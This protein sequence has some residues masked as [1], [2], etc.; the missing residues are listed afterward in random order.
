[1]PELLL[2]VGCE[3][4]PASFVRKAYTD[5]H[6]L[7]AHRL[8]EA[9]VLVD[10]GT[11][12]GTPRRLI[13]SIPNLRERQEDQ[14]KEQR[15]P[16][17]KAAFNEAGD[18]TPAL[19]G[20]CRSQGV[21]P[22]DLRQE[23][24]YVWV[25]KV[26]PG[27][28]TREL[29][30]EAIPQALRELSFEK[31]MRW[32][33]ARMRFARPIRWILASLDGE[34]VGFEVESVRSGLE[35]RGHRFYA[36]EVFEAKRLI[37]LVEGLRARRVEPNPAVRRRTI[38]ETARRVASGEPEMSEALIDENV[39]L[40][41]WPTPLQGEYRSEFQV[42]PEPVLVTAMAKHEKM[43]PVRGDDGLLTTQFIFVR[44]SGV[45]DEV[46]AGTEWVLNARF[47]DAKFFF[48]E[49][50]THT[51]DEFLERTAGIVVQEKLG[52]VRQRADRLATLASE[53][54]LATGADH[55]E[56]VL[57]R[58]A[59][60]Y[61]KADLSTG[62]VSELP[63]LQGVVGGE[64]ARREGM[65]A[66]VCHAVASQYDLSKNLPPNDAARRTGVRL[67]LADQLDK[68][69][70]YLGIGLEP[71]GSSDPYGLRRAGT[72]LIQASWNWEGPMPPFAGLLRRAEELY[73]EQG[74]ALPSDR[75][76]EALGE[77][78]AGRYEA[79]LPEVRHDLLEAALLREV[80]DQLTN[81]R[82]VRFR[83]S[84][85][86]RISD[87]VPFVQAATRPLNI[88][89]AARKKG[90]AFD[91]MDPLGRLDLAALDSAEGAVLNQVLQETE[92]DL[93]KAASEESA[94][95][96]LQS[97]KKLETPINRF[98]DSTM[99]MVEQEDVRRARLSLLQAASLQ[100]L[101]AGDFSKIVV[102]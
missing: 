24:G 97:L 28:S 4:L 84:V 75:T 52:N 19:L 82:G 2:E 36:P 42:L 95:R 11:S 96:V 65:L 93:M 69:A 98:F 7:I 22:S 20:F 43:F 38:V 67:L 102:A 9:G 49:D 14:T 30:A 60:L 62:L 83:T 94:D 31:S 74:F 37:D 68:L 18:P 81:P 101:V 99:I 85:L 58:S 25:T 6:A 70:G 73:R 32:G 88:V 59:G 46:R 47:N 16:G 57:A 8:R 64:Y 39:F 71:S 91:E 1:M 40:T 90:I 50:V 72:L 55:A 17:L 33:A 41:E 77:I 51:L 23:G 79:M 13:V 21:D 100:L 48:D 61:A 54:A 3:E 80:A 56:T 35:S 86:T 45:D 76:A 53:I 44:N 87:D 78:L 10:E 89:A 15:G 12:M 27:R 5:L 26:V 29:L 63:S 92:R 34:V 66:E